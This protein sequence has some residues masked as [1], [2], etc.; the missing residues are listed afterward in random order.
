[1]QARGC[2]SRRIVEPLSNGDSRS[3]AANGFLAGEFA[4]A[5]GVP[6]LPRCRR[7][8]LSRAGLSREGRRLAHEG[9]AV[10]AASEASRAV[11]SCDCEPAGFRG[12]ALEQFDVGDAALFR[13]QLARFN[14]RFVAL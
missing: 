5:G 8:A 13:L 6:E 11:W 7:S 3:R 12:D 4:I 2:R 14:Q 1:M 10:V 9:Q